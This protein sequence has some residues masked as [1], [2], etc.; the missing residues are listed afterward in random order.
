MPD[1]KTSLPHVEA[2]QPQ[3]GKIVSGDTKHTSQWK[4]P[5]APVESKPAS[6]SKPS[7]PSE[8]KPAPDSKS[9]S[10]TESKS[11]HDRKIKR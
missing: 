10:Q 5:T 3:D 6:E 11:S 7:S 9:S 8:S 2:K 4:F 1:S